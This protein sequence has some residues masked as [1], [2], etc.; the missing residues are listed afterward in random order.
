MHRRRETIAIRRRVAGRAAAGMEHHSTARRPR[1][2]PKRAVAQQ[3][4]AA[5]ACG[6]AGIAAPQGLDPGR[7]PLW[8]R[9]RHPAHPP[10]DSQLGSKLRQW[11]WQPAAAATAHGGSTERAAAPAAAAAATGPATA[12]R[13]AMARPA[14]LLLPRHPRC[15]RQ[16]R[17]RTRRRRLR[18]WPHFLNAP[19]RDLSSAA[20][21]ASRVTARAA[22]APAATTPTVATAPRTRQAVAVPLGPWTR[23]PH[24]LARVRELRRCP[25]SRSAWMAPSTPA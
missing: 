14:C 25:P 7:P 13:A 19:P 15:P 18:R 11:T 23:R 8:K 3:R 2:P 9:L 22:P 17:R 24:V 5:A 1:P 21:I 16:A 4:A 10:S 12:M 6:I 20:R